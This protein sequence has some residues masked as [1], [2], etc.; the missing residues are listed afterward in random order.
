MRKGVGKS[1]NEFKLV[2]ELKKSAQMVMDSYR[3][4]IR[5]EYPT[6]YRV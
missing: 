2:E 3:G 4:M 6:Q 5:I 1:L